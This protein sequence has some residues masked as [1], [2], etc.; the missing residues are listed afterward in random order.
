MSV[1]VSI[2][3][4]GI[5]NL[6][7]VCRALENIGADPVLAAT[8]SSVEEADRVVL[9]GVGAIGPAMRTLSDGGLAD[10]ITE[11]AVERQ[12]PFLGICLGMQ[13]MLDRSSEFGDHAGLGMI[14]GTVERI[15]D[16]GDDNTPH[17]IPH[18]GWAPLGVPKHACWSD[19][20]LKNCP[21]GSNVYFVH[22]YVARPAVHQHCIAVANY[23]GLALAATIGKDNLWGCQFHPEKSGETGLSI[24]KSFLDI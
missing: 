22:S 17:R 20:I 7:S 10:A 13:M 5:G 3:D 9:P 14:S 11:V 8:P 6:L 23:D 24:L 1:K 18:I 12:R 4:Y 19:T 15:P 2:V 16:T 21:P